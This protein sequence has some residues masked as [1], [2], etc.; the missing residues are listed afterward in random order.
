MLVPVWT[1]HMLADALTK[2]IDTPTLRYFNP[3]FTRNISPVPPDAGLMAR[4][5][6]LNEGAKKKFKTWRRAC[7]VEER[8]PPE[9]R[10]TVAVAGIFL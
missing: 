9:Q 6:K 4:A 7:K 1:E 3:F 8:L 5:G 2:L 10:V